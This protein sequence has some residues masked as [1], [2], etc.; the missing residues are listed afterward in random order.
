M[1][2]PF[3]TF[4]TSYETKQ[5]YANRIQGESTKHP[6]DQVAEEKV[7]PSSPTSS[8][9][10]F[11]EIELL[12]LRTGARPKTAAAMKNDVKNTACDEGE[13]QEGKKFRLGGGNGGKGFGGE[14]IGGPNEERRCVERACLL[15][16]IGS[17]GNYG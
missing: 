1:F 15:R 16:D 5:D 3:Q 14:E 6:K 7:S 17:N 4:S 2:S 11:L 8:S 10:K 12:G 9:A 13:K